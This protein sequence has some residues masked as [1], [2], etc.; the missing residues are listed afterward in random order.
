MECK[1]YFVHSFTLACPVFDTAN[2]GTP[3]AP[4][5]CPVKTLRPSM[6]CTRYKCSSSYP[7]LTE[8]VATPFSPAPQP[9]PNPD[10]SF[11]F[12]A[13]IDLEFDDKVAIGIS[14]GLILL[15]LFLALMI[16]CLFKR[17]TQQRENGG[18]GPDRRWRPSLPSIRPHLRVEEVGPFGLRV[19]AGFTTQGRNV[20]VGRDIEMVEM[21]LQTASSF[22]TANMTR[23]GT[24]DDVSKLPKD[25]VF[26]PKWAS[27]PRHGLGSDHSLNQGQ[28]FV[29]GQSELKPLKS[30]FKHSQ[31]GSAQKRKVT[32]FQ[33]NE[34]EDKQTSLPFQQ[35]SLTVSRTYSH[36]KGPAPLPPQIV[37]QKAFVEI[38]QR[39][40]ANST[41][42]ASAFDEFQPVDYCAKDPQGQP[43]AVLPDL[44][45][46]AP[47]TATD[48][49]LQ[50]VDNSLPNLY[51][52]DDLA[53]RMQ[54]AL[55]IATGVSLV[56]LKVMECKNAL[57]HDRW[58]DC[59]ECGFVNHNFK[60]PDWHRYRSS[61]NEIDSH[62]LEQE[63]HEETHS[64][65]DETN[66]AYLTVDAYAATDEFAENKTPLEAVESVAANA[67]TET[68]PSND[69]QASNLQIGNAA[70]SSTT[71]ALPV[72]QVVDKVAAYRSRPQQK[73]KL[74]LR[75][76]KATG[77]SSETF[78]SSGVVRKPFTRNQAK[79]EE[80]Q[81]NFLWQLLP[82]FGV[83]DVTFN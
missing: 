61:S 33:V 4:P 43:L 79:L 52:L 40:L 23:A 37:S 1:P 41:T 38:Q 8:G 63:S 50:T 3:K 17:R 13:N 16:W 32:R 58:Y 68:V 10:T 65:I 62:S 27:T 81:R 51:E 30:A 18:Q 6:G 2:C 46:V 74:R 29:F 20:Q 21:G 42:F 78:A 35:K 76:K 31:I 49:N 7:A 28:P 45:P 15:C 60:G 64:I 75:A 11:S 12:E 9:S 24:A 66:S 22:Q 25:F 82:F 72:G 54:Q 14:V 71:T 56:E 19:D 5:L 69:V 80:D 83:K 57:R 48:F 39:A 36:R 47:Q 34:G 55:T 70:E 77:V 67:E 26:A 59:K 53:T 44:Q 73:R